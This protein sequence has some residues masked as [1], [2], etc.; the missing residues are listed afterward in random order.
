MAAV[1]TEKGEA[2]VVGTE[3]ESTTTSLLNT[4]KSAATTG[5][6]KMKELDEKHGI[7][8]KAKAGLEA[9]MKKASELDEKHGISEKVKAHAELAMKKAKEVDEQYKLS[10]K[11]SATLNAGMEKA[12]ELDGQYGVSETVTAKMK[13]VDEKYQVSQKI[14]AADESLGVTETVKKTAAVVSEKIGMPSYSCSTAFLGDVPVTVSVVGSTLKISP[15]EGEVQVVEVTTELPC[16][17]VETI[18]TVGDIALTLETADE[19]AKLTEAL[20]K[21]RPKVEEVVVVEN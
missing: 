19:A 10:E 16:A 11:A 4:L 13:E 21:A 6:A 12:K 20:E 3:G 1:E 17:A 5:M 14:K 2:P 15:K 8:E 18:V 9:G 7:T